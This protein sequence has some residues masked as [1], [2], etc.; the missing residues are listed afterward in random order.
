MFWKVLDLCYRINNKQNISFQIIRGKNQKIQNQKSKNKFF[1]FFYKSGLFAK[2]G[3]FYR[4]FFGL[5]GPR[6]KF[7]YK[8][9]VT[10]LKMFE[11]IDF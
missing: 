2:S 3:L 11:T 9:K 10:G 7:I 4:K 8:S 5:F 6:N 1:I